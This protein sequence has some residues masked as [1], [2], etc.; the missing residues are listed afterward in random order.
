MTELQLYK[1]IQKCETR[2]DGEETIIWVSHHDI[3]EFIDLIDYNLISDGGIE[4]RLQEHVIALDMVPIC[5]HY[6]IPIENIFEVE[7]E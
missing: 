2:Y 7:N 4:V 6:N 3:P 5:E 1:F